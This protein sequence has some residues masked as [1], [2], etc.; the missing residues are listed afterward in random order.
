MKMF[1]DF[2]RKVA[3]KT[4]NKSNN[5]NKIIDKR[6]AGIIR[7]CKKSIIFAKKNLK[8]NI[9]KINKIIKLQIIVMMLGNTEELRIAYVI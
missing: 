9:W 5:I 7:K 6:A 4:I 1:C 3:M 2:L 8:I